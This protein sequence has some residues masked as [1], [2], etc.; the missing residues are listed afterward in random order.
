MV[1]VTQTSPAAGTILPGATTTRPAVV[2]HRS[3]SMAPMTVDR[4]RARK[5]SAA[6]AGLLFGLLW[7]LLGPASPASAHAALVASDPANGT[8]VPDAPN[9]VSLTFSESVQLITGK[10]QVLAPDGSR[11]DQG[12]PQQTGNTVTIPLRSGGGRGT[13][14]VSFRVVSA[15][16]HPIG[17]TVSYSVGAASAPPKATLARPLA[18]GGGA[19]P[20]EGDDRRQQGRPGGPGTDPGWQIPRVR[21]PG[22]ADRSLAG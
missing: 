22:A 3:G 18:G 21:G 11:A 14:L 20:A 9:K 16:T 12:D 17:G 15:D 5:V 2:W 10:I 4:P 19:G 1:R 8:I 6:C 7:V 13:Y